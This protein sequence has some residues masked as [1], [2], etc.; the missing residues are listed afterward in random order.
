VVT[1]AGGSQ[2]VAAVEGG[3]VDLVITDLVMRGQEGLKTL[4]I[5]SAGPRCR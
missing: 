3:G 4:K 1:T 2:G 5:F